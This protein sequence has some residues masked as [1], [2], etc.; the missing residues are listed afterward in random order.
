VSRA[1]RVAVVLALALLTACPGDDPGARR[2]SC[3]KPSGLISIGE[4]IP[5]TCELEHFEGGLLRLEELMGKPSVINFWATWCTFC[6]DEMPAIEEATLPVRNR[7]AIIG[8]DLLGVDGETRGAAVK[9][10]KKTGVTYD[11]VYDRGGVLFGN[12]SGQLLLP[13]TIFVKA[14][15]V[16]AHRQ[17]GP[18][19]EASL[20]AMLSKYLGVR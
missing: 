8:A 1:R 20:T 3:P 14:D 4:S 10:A 11:L 9:F 7:V 5:G 17:F 18:L 15:G 13:V 6:I 12:F 19:T 16:V 2:A